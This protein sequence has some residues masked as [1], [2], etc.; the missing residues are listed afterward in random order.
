NM[1]YKGIG[2]GVEQQPQQS[3]LEDAPP[4]AAEQPRVADPLLEFDKDEMV[5]L[6]RLHEEEVGIMY[7]VLD[8]QPVI[9]HAK[10]LASLI[11]SMRN[12]RPLEQLN[13]EKTLRLKMVM[14]CALVA[15]EHGHSDKAV[16][17]FESME[18]VVNRKLMSD[19]S[20]VTNLP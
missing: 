16:R 3:S 2:E 4:P 18:A 19:A 15:E 17:L 5:R 1:G 7:P 14:C 6:C 13:D 10:S 11:E 8:I 12:Q 20:C 9:S